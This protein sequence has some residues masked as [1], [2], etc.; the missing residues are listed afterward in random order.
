MMTLKETN[1]RK[2]TILST[3][4]LL[5][6]V[7]MANAENLKNYEI[8][9]RFDGNLGT[10]KPSNDILGYSLTA[11][12]RVKDSWLLGVAFETASGFDIERPNN[13]LPGLSSQ[14]EVDADG[15]SKMVSVW[16][17]RRYSESKYGGYWFWTAGLGL[18]SVDVD[19]VQGT[20]DEGSD[21]DIEF[22]V[23]DE[24]V[25]TLSGGW[26]Y[27]FSNSLFAGIGLRLEQRTGDWV[28][29]D[30]VTGVEETAYDGYSI[31]GLFFS[32]NYRF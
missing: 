6:G 14:Q 16:I 25:V 10:G 32:G 3:I 27:N 7:H 15:D 2:I 12:Y 23:D 28:L 5:F 20:S 18:N 21:Y 30:R 4:I 8:G 1:P 9:A 19:N 11:R 17:E 22:D 31:H 26:R 29:H 24:F 13:E